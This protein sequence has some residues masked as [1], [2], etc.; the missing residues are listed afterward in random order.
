MSQGQAGGNP[1]SGKGWVAYG[2]GTMSTSS[3]GSHG[4]KGWGYGYGVSFTSV[5]MGSGWG[6]TMP[7]DSGYT[8]TWQYT[9][10]YD[11]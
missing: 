1:S 5:N 9:L 6:S 7:S 4:R 3:T 11:V 10:E 8:M 2:S